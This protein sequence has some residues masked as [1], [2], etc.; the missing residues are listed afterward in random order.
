MSL[1][2]SYLRL[3]KA[4]EIQ[5][6]RDSVM[7]QVISPEMWNAKTSGSTIPLPHHSGSTNSNLHVTSR[8]ILTNKWR[9]IFIK[10][11]KVTNSEL[12]WPCNFSGRHCQMERN[13]KI[14]H[15][16]CPAKVR[17]LFQTHYQRCACAYISN[18]YIQI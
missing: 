13:W 12:K 8:S 10:H 1:K 11:K 6:F 5:N 18:V 7:I 15:T 3:K 9:W 16:W 17:N 14:M 2:P 4:S